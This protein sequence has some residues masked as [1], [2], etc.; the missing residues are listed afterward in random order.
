MKSVVK[1]LKV[2][3]WWSQLKTAGSAIY[4]NRHYLDLYR[5]KHPER[6]CGPKGICEI[7]PDVYIHETASIHPTAVVNIQVHLVAG[8]CVILFI[9]TRLDQM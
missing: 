6:L 1:L 9:N 2:N 8:F 4:A 7:I 5:T 3:N